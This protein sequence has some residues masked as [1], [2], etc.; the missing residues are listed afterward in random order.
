MCRVRAKPKADTDW[1]KDGSIK[2]LTGEG[3]IESDNV[4]ELWTSKLKET[5]SSFLILV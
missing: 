2:Q 5:L 3:R 4:L 1:K